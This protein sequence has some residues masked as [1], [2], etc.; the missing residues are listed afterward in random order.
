[1]TD[2]TDIAIVLPQGGEL[3]VIFKREN[4][5]DPILA[6]IEAAAREMV[7]DLDP[8]VKKDRDLM[9][10]AA[11][12]VSQSKAELD[13]QSKALTEVQ[14]AE[15]ASVNAARS[16]ADKFLSDLRDSVRQAADDWDAA[17]EK[18]R[19]IIAASISEITDHGMTVDS[20]SSEIADAAAKIKGRSVTAE[21]FGD[22]LPFAVVAID[23]AIAQLRQFYSAAKR[24]EDDAA[25][26]AKL[27]AEAEAR[28]EADRIAQDRREEAEAEARRIEADRAAK[29]EAVAAEAIRIEN[30]R[31]AAWRHATEIAAARV[32]EQEA[33]AIREADLLRLAEEDRARHAAELAAAAE[34]ERARL[35]A[36]ADA[37]ALAAKKRAQDEAH[38]ATIHRAISDAL[39]LMAG[40]ATPDAIASALMDGKIPHCEVKL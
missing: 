22:Q 29:A 12:K 28:A 13:R 31:L 27:R 10:S 5:I 2:R 15:I 33:A 1:M 25:E 4:G 35:Q 16:K 11:F 14:R 39:A 32:A 34:R 19:A 20:A 7:K 37:E 21:E 38:R 9:R 26:L 23:T 40:N 3:A 30:E 8:A 18:R 6:S 36:I 24:R 17:E